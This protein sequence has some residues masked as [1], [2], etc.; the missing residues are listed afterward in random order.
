MVLA[1]RTRTRI[2]M[3]FVVWRLDRGAIRA[4]IA[5]LMCVS[6]LLEPAVEPLAAKRN[7]A[8]AD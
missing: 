2:V 3:A 7:G 4:R 8:I 6:V 1:D 5:R